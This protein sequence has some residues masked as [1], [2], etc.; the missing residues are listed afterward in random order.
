MI[1]LKKVLQIIHVF[2][3]EIDSSMGESVFS[4]GYDYL[5][6]DEFKILLDIPTSMK[7]STYSSRH[8]LNSASAR[9]TRSV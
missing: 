7:S 9:C 4:V 1:F 6:R 2:L 5:E 3:G 8:S